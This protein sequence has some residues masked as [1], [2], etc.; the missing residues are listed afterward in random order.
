MVH[1]EFVARRFEIH[2][3]VT[4]RSLISSYSLTGEVCEKAGLKGFL[5]TFQSES[6]PLYLLNIWRSR[7]LNE[8]ENRLIQSTRS[9]WQISIAERNFLLVFCRPS[10]RKRRSH[11]Q[12]ENA[13]IIIVFLFS[14]VIQSLGPSTPPVGINDIHVWWMSACWCVTRKHSSIIGL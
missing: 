4:R 8:D 12:I 3:K 9:N 7:I 6:R 10:L 2:A 5:F 14:H 1:S 11:G 13:N